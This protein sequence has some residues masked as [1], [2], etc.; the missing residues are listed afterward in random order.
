MSQKFEEE[1][2]EFKQLVQSLNQVI[3]KIPELKGS[4]K[5]VEIDK[6]KH[7]MEDLEDLIQRME[8]IVRDAPLSQRSSL[9][10]EVRGFKDEIKNLG[11]ELRRSFTAP[12]GSLRKELFD[13]YESANS[14]PLISKEEQ[15]SQLFSISDK[16]KSVSSRITKVSNVAS[17]TEEIGRAVIGELGSQRESILRTKDKLNSTNVKIIESGFLVRSMI[18][19]ASTNKYLIIIAIL[20]VLFVIGL[21][22]Y[23]RYFKQL[24]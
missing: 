22:I 12:Q 20:F 10:T 21:L 23:W 6:G 13:D 11:T 16:M 9:S 17:E 19:R 1:Y 24:N 14:T 7:L 5:Q 3:T 8:N 18:R 15:R 4:P 2:V